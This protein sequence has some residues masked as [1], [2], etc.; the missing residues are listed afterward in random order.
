MIDS[1]DPYRPSR[2]RP[3]RTRSFSLYVLLSSFGFIAIGT[4][5]FLV[6]L[7]F[8]FQLGTK[9]SEVSDYLAFAGIGAVVFGFLINAGLSLYSVV[10]MW[11]TKGLE[12]SHVISL[13]LSCTL[14]VGVFL[15]LRL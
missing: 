12:Y 14:I 6:G 1:P 5:F 13:L 4:C 2:T 10:R 3:D 8:A 11:Q 9:M 7:K 15:L